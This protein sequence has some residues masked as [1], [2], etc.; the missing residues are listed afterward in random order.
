[1]IL[2]LTLVAACVVAPSWSQFISQEVDCGR[3]GK[4]SSGGEF[5][6]Q[7]RPF[8]TVPDCK[9]GNSDDGIVLRL[10]TRDNNKVTDILD[11]F[12]PDTIKRSHFDVKRQTKL[13]I[14]G[15]MD[16]YTRDGWVLNM[17]KLLQAGDFNV[18]RV[19]WHTGN[20]APYVQASA[21]LRLVGAYVAKFLDVIVKMG[22]KPDDIHIIGHSLGAHGAGY[23]G[24]N[25][26]KLYNFTV[27]RITG[28]DPAGPYFGYTPVDVRLDPTDAKVVDT[29]ISNGD[30]DL[31]F[32]S[33]QSMGHINF[34]P[35][36]GRQ[37]PGCSKAVLSSIN[38]ATSA[39]DTIFDQIWKAALLE[40]RAS[41]MS[42]ASFKR[43]DPAAE[44]NAWDAFG[45]SHNFAVVLHAGGINNPECSMTSYQ[46]KDYSAFLG[47]DPACA[48]HPHTPMG[49]NANLSLAEN[50]VVKDYYTVSTGKSPYCAKLMVSFV[51]A[52]SS[53]LLNAN[54]P[55]NGQAFITLTGES[56]FTG[57]LPLTK[58][59][60]DFY[61]NSRYQYVPEINNVLG[62]LR[63]L[64]LSFQ[65]NRL[66][67]DTIKTGS[68]KL[69][70]VITTT[71]G[72]GNVHEFTPVS[73][74]IKSG[75]S[76][77]AK[78]TGTRTL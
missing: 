1:M 62:E 75:E 8:S 15:F 52:N 43:V 53:G 2:A 73:Q 64:T 40:V 25:A 4:Y 29:I 10:N 24:L 12:K 61:P 60:V 32:G 3:L 30:P 6:S 67:Q 31:A 34:H 20:V 27:G 58:N 42:I 50:G 14:H 71:D 59:P 56:G 65:A 13:L 48:L 7:L 16:R 76:V 37:Q 18:I 38:T 47:G 57:K 36:G 51:I 17:G 5:F 11:P 23:A 54:S 66:Q 39:S 72:N 63:T 49:Y 77:L 69:A 35:N 21:N 44:A 45:C 74:E 41:V 70:G 9:W 55:V 33:T 19:D 22:A 28:L 26:R 78:L 46:C 68:L